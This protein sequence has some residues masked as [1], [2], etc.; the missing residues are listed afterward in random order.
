MGL[1]VYSDLN[2]SPEIDTEEAVVTTAFVP[3]GSAAKKNLLL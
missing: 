3:E 1:Y 2:N